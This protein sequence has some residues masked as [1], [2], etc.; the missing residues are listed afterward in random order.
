MAD[1]TANQSGD[2]NDSGK[3]NWRGDQQTTPI[4][5]SIYKSSSVQLAELGSRLVVGDKVF[6][7]A[8]LGAVAVTP[9]EVLQCALAPSVVVTAGGTDASGGRT[10]T[11]FHTAS[12][13][14]A[15]LYAEG[16]LHCASG[17]AANMG[18]M[19][20]IKSHPLIAT[21]AAG[22]LTL[23]DP[24]ITKENVTDKW[25]CTRNPY[26]LVTQATAATAAA[27]G[28][29]VC[30]ATT[31]DYVWIQTWGPAA[32][33]AQTGPAG[34]PMYIAAT[35]AAVGFIATGTGG[36]VYA[37]IGIWGVSP[38]ASDRGYGFLTIAP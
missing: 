31:N 33:K 26:K 4:G 15:N 22:V 1:I 21:D 25:Q 8:Q 27:A 6:R 9:G 17:T 14:A 19:Y 2:V 30:I 13:A 36:T 5:Q 20:R 18:Q 32:V 35:G 23:Y 12:G 24:L 3:V 37:Q 16:Y 10:F 29:L 28:V 11:F 38:T 7:Y 34:S